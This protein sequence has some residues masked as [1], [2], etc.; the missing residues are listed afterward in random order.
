MSTI[1]SD[2]IGEKILQSSESITKSYARL[3]LLME[4][5]STIEFRWKKYNT[6]KRQNRLEEAWQKMPIL[7][8]PDL[9]EYNRTGY[10]G[11]SD[12]PAVFMWPD[13]S[14]RA[15]KD[16]NTLLD[17][18]SAR[19]HDPPYNFLFADR[20]AVEFGVMTSNIQQENH[21]AETYDVV[22]WN[23]AGNRYG[24]LLKRDVDCA[25]T[26]QIRMNAGDGLL[27]LERQQ[28]LYRF[29]A[30]V[31][32]SLCKDM[33]E[34][35]VPKSSPEQRNANALLGVRRH[36]FY[37]SPVHFDA[38]SLLHFVDAQL[39]AAEDHMRALREDPRYFAD[40]LRERKD[41]AMEHVAWSPSARP[42]QVKESWNHTIRVVIRE[43]YAALGMWTAVKVQLQAL[44][45][46]MADHGVGLEPHEALSQPLGDALANM[47]WLLELM[48]E[49]PFATFVE[50]LPPSPMMRDSFGKTITPDGKLQFLPTQQACEDT[51]KVGI[52][53]TVAMLMNKDIR[54]DVGLPTLMDLFDTVLLKDQATVSLLSPLVMRTISDL[55]ALA[56]CVREIFA[57]QPWAR[58]IRSA[59]ERKE[60]SFRQDWEKAKARWLLP[61]KAWNQ[62]D[63]ATSGAP[64]EERFAYPV[65]QKPSRKRTNAMQRAE[66]NLDKF[67][68]RRIVRSWTT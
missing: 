49:M 26:R 44:S 39:D 40:M 46:L 20:E 19:C 53:R 24:E 58:N 5:Y 38:H 34:E 1:T 48:F 60:A 2:E 62:S 16:E 10:D 6:K 22:F 55:S 25:K 68:G 52:I 45:R 18:L 27:V 33:P 64:V 9:W 13:I 12:N 35:S 57:F 61:D 54:K 8:R 14:L 59:L 43:A 7:Q 67:W 4:N 30:D 28:R 36:S 41:H 50:V 47:V 63:L 65:N 15:L 51:T 23:D 42:V 56:E 37:R 17:F 29:L 32:T 3:Q 11:S 31:A 21:L 66:A